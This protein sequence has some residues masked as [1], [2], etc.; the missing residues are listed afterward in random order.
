MSAIALTTGYK[1][2]TLTRFLTFNIGAFAALIGALLMGWPQEIVAADS[3]RITWAIA[4]LF[5]VGWLL[6]LWRVFEIG[7][8]LD[9]ASEHGGEWI[10]HYHDVRA[11]RGD[12]A[13]QSVVELRL[14]NHIAPIRQIAG[15][16][17]ILGLIGTVIGFIAA[18]AGVTTEAATNT[19]AAGRMITEAMGGMSVAL[20]TTLCGAIGNMW[21]IS[22]YRILQ[23]GANHLAV[24][25]FES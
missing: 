19:D 2:L 14:R 23:G 11:R 24:R 20:Y 8:E 5:A 1:D 4:G 7:A 13:A 16:L 22:C 18:F 6:C 21:L 15:V 3:S 25:V 10:G 17:V 12:A 9:A